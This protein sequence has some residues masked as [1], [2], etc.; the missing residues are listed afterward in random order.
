MVVELPCHIAILTKI[1]CVDFMEISTLLDK[2]GCNIEVVDGCVICFGWKMDIIQQE[3]LL[4]VPQRVDPGF[5]FFQ[6]VYQ[7]FWYRHV[8]T[9]NDYDPGAKVPDSIE[10]SIVCW[11]GKGL[12]DPVP[13]ITEF[14]VS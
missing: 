6:N 2:P 10:V 11:Y 13:F 8:E 14:K 7:V 4:V 1:F 9:F 12:S 5:K 3:C